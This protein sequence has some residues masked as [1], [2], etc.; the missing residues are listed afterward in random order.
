MPKYATFLK[1]LLKNKRKLE[2]VD[3]VALNGNSSKIMDKKISMKLRD[4]GS[5]V[6]PCLLGDD[7][8]EN[9]LTNFR[10]S[11]NLADRSVRR[12]WGIV[13]DVL[14]TVEKLVFII[15]FVIFDIDEDVETPLILGRPFLNTSGALINWTNGK[16]TLKVGDEEVVYQ[17]PD[18]MKYSDVF[19]VNPP[20]N[21]L[22]E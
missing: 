13:E 9:T 17:L 12:L 8:E 6:I 20:H 10:A 22:E 4:P 11:I 5:F 14:V 21:Y 3:M 16:M 18:A 7:V 19:M 15:G 1:D 2:E